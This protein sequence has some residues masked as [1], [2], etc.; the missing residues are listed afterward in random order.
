MGL[1]IQVEPLPQNAKSR[2][3][4]FRSF[5]NKHLF[6]PASPDANQMTGVCKS[7]IFTVEIQYHSTIFL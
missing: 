1:W 6:I 5:K 2:N 7:L 3:V 4:G